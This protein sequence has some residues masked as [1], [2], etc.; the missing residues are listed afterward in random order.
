MDRNRR[1]TIRMSHKSL[2]DA[3]KQRPSFME[4][5]HLLPPYTVEDVIKSYQERSQQL[6]TE[7][8]EAAAAAQRLQSAYE[9]A[10]DHARFQESRRVWLGGRMEVFQERQQL[11]VEI[12]AAG[13]LVSLQSNDSYVY[14]YGVDFAEIPASWSPSN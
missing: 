1:P 9:R 3:A 8:D 6:P 13:G 2:T 14:E 5:L 12:E 4:L 10:L 11:I 7:D